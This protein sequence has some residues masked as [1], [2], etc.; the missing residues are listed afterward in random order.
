MGQL[1]KNKLAELVNL[2]PTPCLLRLDRLKAEGFITG[3][4]ADIALE[5]IGDFTQVIVAIELAHHRESDF[6]L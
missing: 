3:Y 5:R 4:R 1:S 6:G 2:S